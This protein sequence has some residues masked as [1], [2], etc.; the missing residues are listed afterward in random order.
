MLCVVFALL[1]WSCQNRGEA[2]P[3][4]PEPLS[5]EL[6]SFNLSEIGETD[7]ALLIGE[8][9][10]IAF[11]YTA[12]GNKILNRTAISK[13][14]LTIP[15]APF[16]ESVEEIEDILNDSERDLNSRWHFS[17]MNWYGF[18]CL[19]L[20]GNVIEN[21]PRGSS[22]MYVKPPHLEY[23]LTFALTATR[24]FVIKDN[25]LIFYFPKIKDKDLLSHCTVI[26]NKNLL[27]FKK[28]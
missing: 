21:I 14:K 1:S 17:C 18:F 28:Q 9:D 20:G 5:N 3:P 12:D 2:E 25:E 13:G 15:N 27:I 4:L 22:Y 26:E 19:P 7:P 6:I 24:S 8:W 16:I 11:A 10:A 23:D